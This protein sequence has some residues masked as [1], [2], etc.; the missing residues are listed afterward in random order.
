MDGIQERALG[1]ESEIGST[2]GESHDD[3]LVK[4]LGR[5]RG[6]EVAIRRGPPPPRR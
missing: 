6:V 1:M 2:S 3:V 5:E 4:T